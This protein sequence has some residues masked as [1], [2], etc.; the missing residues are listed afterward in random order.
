MLL[1]VVK[2]LVVVVELLG[3]RFGRCL[4]RM[5][6]DLPDG[7]TKE[8][9]QKAEVKVMGVGM[10]AMQRG[11]CSASVYACGLGFFSFHF[12]SSGSKIIATMDLSEAFAFYELNHASITGHCCGG[13]DLNGSRYCC[14]FVVEPLNLCY[15]YS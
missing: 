8:Q 1:L 13:L 7:M 3:T 4:F 11:E 15:I 10:S 6:A 12:E 2:V 14:H 9:L 5:L